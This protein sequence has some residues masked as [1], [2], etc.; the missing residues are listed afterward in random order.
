MKHTFPTELSTTAQYR[1][2]I[3]AMSRRNIPFLSA[4]YFEETRQAVHQEPE[5]VSAVCVK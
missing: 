4:Q 2:P 5:T 3:A 1:T